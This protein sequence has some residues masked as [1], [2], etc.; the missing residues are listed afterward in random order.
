MVIQDHPDASSYRAS[1]FSNRIGWGKSPA[2]ILIDVCTAYW[3]KGSPLDTSSN[4]ASV[5]SVDVMKRLLAAARG[6]GV[7]VIWTVVRY[8]NEDMSDAGIFW[9]KSKSLDVWKKGDTRGFDKFV[10]DLEPASGE[11]VI[12]K[13]YPSGFFGTDMN[14][15]LTVLGIDTVVICGVSTSG[16]VRATALD[17]MQ[18]GYRPMVSPQ[19][20][21]R[22]HAC[23]R[24]LTD[25]R[26]SVLLVATAQ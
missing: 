16:C 10:E 21:R 14:T 15:R 13:K 17:A 5:A 22:L 2:L 1:G 23:C 12:P 6:S 4:P 7:P 25:C 11:I 19:L 3:S 9:L 18:H 20:P 24:S 8:E 26:S